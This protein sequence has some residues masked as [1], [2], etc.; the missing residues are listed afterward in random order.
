[1][2]K[3]K[4]EICGKVKDIPRCCDE[5]MMVQH[6]LLCCCSKCGYV[7]KP[8]CCGKVMTYLSN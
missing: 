1:M 4:C 8:K 6:N 2:P 7:E 3:L 5:S